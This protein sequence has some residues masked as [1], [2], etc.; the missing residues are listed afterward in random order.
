MI[1]LSLIYIQVA[2]VYIMQQLE[3]LLLGLIL[4]II[5]KRFVTAKFINNNYQSKWRILLCTWFN[6]RVQIEYQSMHYI[7]VLKISCKEWF[8]QLN[9]R[10]CN[11]QKRIYKHFIKTKLSLITQVSTGFLL[12]VM[13]LLGKKKLSLNIRKSKNKLKKIKPIF[14]VD[15]ELL[16]LLFQVKIFYVLQDLNFQV[17]KLFVFINYLNI[18]AVM[19][20]VLKMIVRKYL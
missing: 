9:W 20:T 14:Q 5:I 17:T 7:K 10:F 19:V 1:S 3:N 11:N 12:I 18:Y 6:L 16:M 13:N 8:L 4:R 15:L 2:F